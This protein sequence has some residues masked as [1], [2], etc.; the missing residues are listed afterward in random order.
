MSH[1]QSEHQD[2]EEREEAPSILD[3]KPDTRRAADGGIR[4]PGPLEDL[5]EGLNEAG[6]EEVSV[7]DIVEAFEHRSIGAL[8][9]VI[10]LISALPI[11][12]GIPGMTL[13]TATMILLVV[14]ESLIR[15]RGGIWVPRVLGRR[16][17][18]ADKLEKAV[19]KTRPYVR[20][21]DKWMHPR[22]EFLTRGRIR[23]LA[24]T[25]AIVLLTLSFYPLNFIP[26]AV[27]APSFGVLAFGLALMTGDGY[28]ALFGYAMVAATLGIGVE[29]LS[30][31]FGGVFAE[32][33]GS[34]GFLGGLFGSEAK[35]PAEG[36]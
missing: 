35:S 32:Q 24:M 11:V 25:V 2:A 7:D 23:R 33:S 5:L 12:G 20:K 36:G 15:R 9:S 26:Y 6:E 8:V 3:E 21:V 1:T 4:G 34:G 19:A 30:G 29:L 28:L 17:I 13:I 18:S 14:G 10:A 16:S 22:V 31:G 27:S